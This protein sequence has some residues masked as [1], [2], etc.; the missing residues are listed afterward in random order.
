MSGNTFNLNAYSIRFLVDDMQAA[1]DAETNVYEPADIDRM[2]QIVQHF[3]VGS[4][5]LHSLD[6]LI[7]SDISEDGFNQHIREKANENVIIWNDIKTHGLPTKTE[8]E[9]LIADDPEST[10][11][12]QFLVKGECGIYTA[13]MFNDGSGFD[14]PHGVDDT[15]VAWAI[16]KDF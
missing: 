9:K 14:M 2:N 16:I 13:H 8:R 15:P 3:K 6:Y 11:E 5:L 7:A 12:R 4:E 10:I 1:V